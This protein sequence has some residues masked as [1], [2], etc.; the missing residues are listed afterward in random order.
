MEHD[1]GHSRRRFIGGA[2]AAAAAVWTPAFRIPAAQAA[3]TAPHRFPAGI[4]CY[5]QGFVNWSQAIRID[6]L[7]TCAP[8]NAREALAVANWARAHRYRV[9]PRGHMH[10]WSPLTIVPGPS[11]ARRVV[12]LDTTQH[13]TGVAMASATT[14]RAQAGASMESVLT[15]LEQHGLGLTA[16]PAPGDITIAGALAIGGHGTAVPARGE[17][18][19]KGHTFGSLSNLVTS[20]TVVAWSAR[21]GRYVLRT[22]ERGDPDAKAFL[23][24]LGRA[25]V[26]EITLRAGRND[27][28]RCQSLLDIPAAELFA[29]PGDPAAQRTLASFV[30][31]SGRV[32]AIWFPFT[33]R[34][35][36]KVWSV[37][38]TQPAGS[39]ATDAPY[40]YPFADNISLETNEVLDRRTV[41]DPASTP[42]LGRL[43]LD[44][45][46]A[47]LAQGGADL[48]GPSKNLLLYVKP[49]TL[50]VTANGYA[51]LTGRRDIQKVVSQFVA[52]YEERIAA[53]AAKGAYPANGP[54]EIRITGLDRPGDVG[55]KGAQAP[56]LSAVSPRPDHPEWDVAVWL[57]ILTFPDTPG[58]NA[59]MRD[60]ERWVFATYVPPY[61]TVRPEWSK[62]WA[63]TKQAAWADATVL[64][65]RIPAAYRA[66]R[67]RRSDWDWVRG[68]L[69]TADPHR[70]FSNAFLDRLL[71]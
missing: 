59:F 41:T 67:S 8:R 15:L 58:A 2:A 13:L 1:Q 18:R 46:E 64:D 53:D 65:R 42:A 56:A 9:R 69:R 6:D 55:I 30:E 47:A 52:F 39:T 19:T 44:T 34:P 62:G 36:L 32:E 3:G 40:N 5:R 23:T 31:E 10:N 51:I 29:A 33:D 20:I 25:F 35:W 60:V 71:G 38:P 12:L 11:A 7:W 66:G 63:Y 28:L 37:A 16:T 54:L 26:T 57:D 4:D 14:V 21:R 61:A 24:H 17:R 27:N 70:V 43:S 48:W 22:I 49:T 68:R 50:R 45:T